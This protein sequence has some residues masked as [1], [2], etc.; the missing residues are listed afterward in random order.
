[1]F[2]RVVNVQFQPSKVDEASCIVQ[3]AFVPALQ[4]QKGFKGQLLLT[5]RDTGKAI[6]LNLWE[7]ESDQ[8]AFE[9]SPLYRELMGKLAGILAG[10]PAKE[11][12]EVSVQA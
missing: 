3:E 2:A 11:G 5:Q 7:T 1:M 9:T 6:A 10:P 8:N 12:Y 4:G